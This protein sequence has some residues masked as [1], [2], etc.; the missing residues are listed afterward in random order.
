MGAVADR[1]ELDLAEMK[2]YL[3]IAEDDTSQDEDIQS[4]L[5]AAKDDADG[6]LNNP[7]TET[8]VDEETGEE[9]VTPLPIPAAVKQWVKRRVARY[10]DRRVEGVQIETVSGIGTVHWGPD[11]YQGLLPYRMNPGF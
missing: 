5:D 3:G 7:F 11:E 10:I 8:T 4:A 1:L 9:T 6:F 2:R